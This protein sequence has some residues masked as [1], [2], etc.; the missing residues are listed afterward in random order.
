METSKNNDTL[1]IYSTIYPWEIKVKF[2]FKKDLFVSEVK[3]YIT[4]T[5]RGLNIGSFQIGKLTDEN[6][7]ILIGT[8]VRLYF[9]VENR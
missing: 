2:S 6:D 3:N 4:D 9:F 5:I 7:Y 8:Y 1:I